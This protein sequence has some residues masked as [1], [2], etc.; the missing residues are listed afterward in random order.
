MPEMGHL[1]AQIL[2]K[3]MGLEEPLEYAHCWGTDRV[4]THAGIVADA[5]AVGAV[6]VG[7][8][9]DAAEADT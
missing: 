9:V 6:A 4:D 2:D 3:L 7:A 5:V 1:P 8:V